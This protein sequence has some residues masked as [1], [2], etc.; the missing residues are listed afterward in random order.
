MQLTLTCLSDITVAPGR[1]SWP[2]LT[3]MW[4]M[5]AAGGGHVLLRHTGEGVIVRSLCKAC[6]ISFS[7]LNAHQPCQ[8]HCIYEACL[9][10]YK[11]GHTHQMNLF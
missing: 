3:G 10:F 9:W 4:V 1:K 11:A 5:P 7:M 6:T 2:W 8:P